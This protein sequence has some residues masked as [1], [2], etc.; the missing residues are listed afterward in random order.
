[1]YYTHLLKLHSKRKIKASGASLQAGKRML[2]KNTVLSYDKSCFRE[3][4]GECLSLDGKKKQIRK[5]ILQLC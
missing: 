1:M 4:K 5:K 2:F 3:E